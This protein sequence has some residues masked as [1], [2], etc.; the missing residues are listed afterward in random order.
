MLPTFSVAAAALL[1][2]GG[3]FV[4]QVA[5]ALDETLGLSSNNLMKN[6][7]SFGEHGLLAADKVLSGRS[8]TWESCLS[9]SQVSCPHG[10][11]HRAKIS[12]C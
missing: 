2:V 5:G 12:T 10:G 6:G 11:W 7:V 3:L 1:A 9:L 4:P 8:L